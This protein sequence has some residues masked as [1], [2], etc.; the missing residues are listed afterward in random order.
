MKENAGTQ[1][2]VRHLQLLG[3]RVDGRAATDL[4]HLVERVGLADRVEVLL[5]IVHLPHLV[6]RASGE[7]EADGDTNDDANN[8]TRGYSN[9]HNLCEKRM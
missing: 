4:S 1:D 8:G 3:G 7:G 5:G 6:G 2:K 9:R